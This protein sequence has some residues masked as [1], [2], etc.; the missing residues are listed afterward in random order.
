MNEVGRE[1]FELTLK[2]ASGQRS[3]GEKAGHSQVQIWRDWGQQHQPQSGSGGSTGKQDNNNNNNTTNSNNN[4]SFESLISSYE[5]MKKSV[6]DRQS[7]LNN[8][9]NKALQQQQQQQRPL[10]SL[11][12]SS[13]L[14]PLVQRLSMMTY[15]AYE[16]VKGK[17]DDASSCFYATDRLGLI[18]PTSLCSGQ[19]ADIIA[20]HL[21][22]KYKLVPNN[23]NVQETLQPQPTNNE[24]PVTRYVA[25]PHTEGC[26][27]GGGGSS[28]EDLFV[29]TL[30]G[31]L[32][33]PFVE[34]AL[35]L[36]H[37]CEHTHNH[38]FMHK[39]SEVDPK[40]VDS[41]GWA[42]VQVPNSLTILLTC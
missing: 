35:L 2:V 40:L 38:F 18:L 8:S 34:R 20:Q 36:E 23:N 3:V 7:Q 21:N 17:G 13:H 1:T 42:S 4:A 11:S 41:F 15:S 26:G 16:V 24:H 27:C 31:Y 28:W 14:S 6:L 29:Q 32:V 19:I 12:S 22:D 39:M 9:N 37:G 33:H 5:A 25:L 10:Q 30:F